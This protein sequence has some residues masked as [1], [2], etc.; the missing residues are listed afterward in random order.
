MLQKIE[1]YFNTEVLQKNVPE[2]T[3]TT[4]KTLP[5]ARQVTGVVNAFVMMGEGLGMYFLAIS[6]WK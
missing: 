1:H 3:W 4:L 5:M 6:G 2:G